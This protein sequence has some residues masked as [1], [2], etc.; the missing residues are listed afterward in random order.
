MEFGLADLLLSPSS[1]VLR[2]AQ[3]NR[4]NTAM[5]T[6]RS[7]DVDMSDL[8]GHLTGQCLRLSHSPDAVM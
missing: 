4:F 5:A 7:L 2:L 6:A 3:S 1:V 8:F